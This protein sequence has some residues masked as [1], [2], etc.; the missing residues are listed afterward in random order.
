MQ[1]KINKQETISEAA[2]RI[3]PHCGNVL[4]EMAKESFIKGAKWQQEQDDK[5]YSEKDLKTAW[6]ESENN[7]SGLEFGR[8]RFYE[9]FEQFKKK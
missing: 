5:M 7:Y 2:E 3:Y 9:W 8:N 1:E 6:E 4:K